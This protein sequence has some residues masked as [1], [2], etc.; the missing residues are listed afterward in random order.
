MADDG[1]VYNEHHTDSTSQVLPYATFDPTNIRPILQR[2]MQFT[3][4]QVGDR[5][6]LSIG[7]FDG[8]FLG[9]YPA[10]TIRRENDAGFLFHLVGLNRGGDLSV[11]A[12]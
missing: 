11:A 2:Q 5:L 12:P 9:Q 1:T 3:A 7:N 6:S 8:R 10:K 4:D